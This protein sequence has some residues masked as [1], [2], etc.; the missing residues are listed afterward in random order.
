[1]YVPS[2]KQNFL[3]TPSALQYC[4]RKDDMEGLNLTIYPQ[5]LVSWSFYTFYCRQ[6]W[7]SYMSCRAARSSVT[8]GTL[9]EWWTPLYAHEGHGSVSWKCFFRIFTNPIFRVLWCSWLNT[10]TQCVVI[11]DSSTIASKIP[12]REEKG[13]HMTLLFLIT[14]HVDLLMVANDYPV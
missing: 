7:L 8:P 13:P 2:R 3:Q 1:M 10:M 14:Y 4:L 5:H 9:G 11:P 6:L 12:K